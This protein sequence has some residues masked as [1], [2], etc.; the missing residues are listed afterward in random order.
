MLKSD[1]HVR[2]TI[3]PIILV[4]RSTSGSAPA[5]PMPPTTT[6]KTFFPDLSAL[7][8]RCDGDGGDPDAATECK[9]LCGARSLELTQQSRCGLDRPWR[10]S[11]SAFGCS[12]HETRPLPV[13]QEAQDPSKPAAQNAAGLTIS[14]RAVPALKARS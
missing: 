11:C 5:S 2:M 10:I 12:Y 3:P 9:G 14:A 7:I 4:R 1:R 6:M 8:D 13:A